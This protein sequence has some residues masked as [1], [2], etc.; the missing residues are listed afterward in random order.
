LNELKDFLKETMRQY[1]TWSNIRRAIRYR[2]LIIVG[3]VVIVVIAILASAAPPSR[4]QVHNLLKPKPAPKLIID[5]SVADDFRALAVETWTEFLTVFWARS[6]CFGDVR[7]RAT[8][9]LNS[10]AAYDPDTATVM[11]RVPGTPAMLRGALIHEWAHH[12]EFQC[13]AHKDLRPAFLAA[14]GFPPDTLWRPDDTPANT[15]VSAW[16]DIPSEQY[17]EATIELVLGRRQIPT[18][19]RV[20][21]EAIHVIE[22][23]AAGD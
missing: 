5:A 6:D 2:W 12:I 11:V 19:V 15:P 4:G 3:V 18:E 14:Q 9:T 23:W 7:L 10:R 21:Q 20:T 22:V 16:P 17:A 13:E 1:L 8:R